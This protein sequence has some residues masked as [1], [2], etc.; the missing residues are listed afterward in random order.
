MSERSDE[1][2]EGYAA[3]G[4]GISRT[5]NPYSSTPI[6]PSVLQSSKDW[7]EGWNTRFHGEAIYEGTPDP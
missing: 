6:G 5:R 1:F 2:L 4:R 3:C 7:H